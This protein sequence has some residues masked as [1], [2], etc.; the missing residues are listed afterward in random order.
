MDAHKAFRP[1]V[2]IAAAGLL[3]TG[4]ACNGSVARRAAHSSTPAPAV[5]TVAPVGATP[6]APTSAPSATAA[7]RTDDLEADLQHVDGQLSQTS[8]AVGDADQNTQQTSD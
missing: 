6:A 1:L 8:S 2:T 3:L 7:V 5:T 4:A